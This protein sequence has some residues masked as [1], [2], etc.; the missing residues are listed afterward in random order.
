MV[1]YFHAG[2]YPRSLT[3][4]T[5]RL[6]LLW[7]SHY[8]PDHHHIFPSICHC[9]HRLHHQI[10]RACPMS[11]LS[12][13]CPLYPCSLIEGCRRRVESC[14]PTG[15]DIPTSK[16][17]SSSPAARR[18]LREALGAFEISSPDAQAGSLLLKMVS[19]KKFSVIPRTSF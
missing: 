2:C 15:A 12:K 10:S 3:G 1:L 14:A 7:K 18:E 17:P 6:L 19:F 5:K 11:N 16:S 13:Q 8:P 9:R 4:D